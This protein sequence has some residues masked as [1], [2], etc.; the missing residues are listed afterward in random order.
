MTADVTFE[1]E[2]STAACLRLTTVSE[3]NMKKSQNSV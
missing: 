3:P 2:S 1:K